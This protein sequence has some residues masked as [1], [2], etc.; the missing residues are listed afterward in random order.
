MFS[1]LAGTITPW[2]LGTLLV[3]MSL[4][5]AIVFKSWREVKNSPY[6]FMRRQAEKRLQTYLFASLCLIVVTAVTAAFTLQAPPDTT[7]LVAVLTNSKPASEEVVALVESAPTIELVTESSVPEFISAGSIG[8]YKLN[9]GLS[10]CHQS[11]KVTAMQTALR[12]IA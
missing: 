7:P 3:L 10:V 9:A 2:I 8:I 5:L 1:S 11:E 4:A 12:Q 6:Y